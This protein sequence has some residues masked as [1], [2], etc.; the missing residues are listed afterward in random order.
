MRAEKQ[1]GENVLAGA[2]ILLVPKVYRAFRSGIRI[3][4]LV[5]LI[6]RQSLPVDINSN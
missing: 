3:S 4:T 2:S 1:S 5:E 6:L